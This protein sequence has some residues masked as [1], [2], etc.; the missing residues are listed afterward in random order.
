M[1]T[2]RPISA[3]GK[4]LNILWRIGA[5]QARYRFSGDFYMMLENF[6]GALCDSK[7]FV[8]FNEIKDLFQTN[9]VKVY[10]GCR[11]IIVSRGISELPGYKKVPAELEVKFCS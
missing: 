11:R 2:R 10:E 4:T 1:I 6:P 8:V 7:G 3:Y 5:R 9:G